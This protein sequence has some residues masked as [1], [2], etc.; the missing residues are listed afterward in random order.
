MDAISFNDYKQ[1]KLFIDMFEEEADHTLSIEI[2][3]AP[4]DETIE[5]MGTP[6]EL[7]LRIGFEY[8]MIPLPVP[9]LIE[10]AHATRN[11]GIIGIRLPKKDMK[12]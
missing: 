2:L 6:K 8:H 9:V 12:A 7:Q 3:G 1:H 11:N 4:I 5:I 10:D